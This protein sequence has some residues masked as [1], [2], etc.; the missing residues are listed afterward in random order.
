MDSRRSTVIVEGSLALRHR[1]I[2][3]ARTSECGVQIATLT[4]AASRLAGG[5]LRLASAE[6][7]ERAVR[8]SLAEAGFAELDGIR[9]LPGMTR[10]AARTLRKLWDAD[11]DLAAEARRAARIADLRLLEDRV[12]ARLP[13][14]ALIPRD[15][16]EAA[17]RR[18]SHAGAVLGAVELDG[19]TQV[20]PVWRPLLV[21][22]SS[23]VPLTWRARA[24]ADMS[25]FNGTLLEFAGAAQP[26]ELVSC[27][28]PR[29]EVVEALR[30]VR[31]LLASGQAAAGE[32]AVAATSPETWDDH[33]FALTSDAELPIHFSHG[34]PA[35]AMRDGQ[36]CAALADILLNGLSRERVRRLARL[37]AGDGTPFDG[38]P[39][40]WMSRL[41][42]EAG[43]LE[44]GHWRRALAAA[45]GRDGTQIGPLLLPL[46][47]EMAVGPSRAEAIGLVLMKGRAGRLWAEALRAAPA[48]ALELSLKELR[49]EDGRDPGNSVIWCPASHLAGA[50]RP[51]VR[52]LGM[53][54]RAWPRKA[55]DDPLVPDH[56]LP[57]SALDPDPVAERDRR[58][59][60]VICGGAARG[61]I[62][63]RSRRDAQGR[64][65]A[66]SPLLPDGA[67]RQLRRAR[68]PEHAFSEADRLLARPAEGADLLRIVAAVGC[69][70]D[71]QRSEVTPHDGLVRPDHPAILDSLGQ[72]Q[73]PT[74][75]RRMLR[76]PLGFVWRYALGWDTA[77]QEEPPLELDGAAFGLLVHELLR[78]AVDALGPAGAF[79]RAA[80]HE[81]E[82]AV[83]GA[84]KTIIED[85]PLERSVPPRL[86][87]EHTVE[88]AAALS[89]AALT[90]DGP[91]QPGTR[92]WTELPFG[93]PEPPLPKRELP[94]DPCAPVV[95]P[96]TDVR[97]RGSIDRLDL[98]GDGAAVRVTDYKSGAPPKKPDAVVI[99]G[100]AELQRALYALAARQLLPDVRKIDARLIYLGD[101]TTKFPLHRVDEALARISRFVATAAGLLR[102]GTVLAGRDAH[103]RF[104]DLRLA[105]PANAASGY[106]RSKQSAFA[107]ALA[108]LS[109]FWSEP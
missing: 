103:E 8:S 89:L 26:A 63:S 47:S 46:L 36:K 61:L 88:T 30:W 23:A 12:R 78:R 80:L 57:R 54:S 51:W 35:L 33:F 17:L 90:F 72:T 37:V 45:D 25:W 77:P 29:A 34:V 5:F 74:S 62:L 13:A 108:G 92:S 70:R 59:F 97:V 32:V 109:A 49:V 58:A 1:R 67:S 10:A 69:W 75:L 19:L 83:A 100:G 81:V 82:A 7:L 65:L 22:L 52:L 68:V 91:F 3:A 50:P 107:R 99:A 84:K 38:L 86:L 20:P 48:E 27:A 102:A 101:E 95:I 41:P 4:Q 39:Q 16:R 66:P 104:Y 94:W 2:A 28:D 76:D 87:W 98:T 11:V 93:E 18:L 56:V 31:E 60:K 79:S 24:Q 55:G 9:A 71:W 85:W 40:D 73:S 21:A 96:G 105:L 53:T 42:R 64:L 15:L 14:G 43:L 6:E 44:F 106:L